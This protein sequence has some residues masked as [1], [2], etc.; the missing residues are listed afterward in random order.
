MAFQHQDIIPA[1]HGA[2]VAHMILPLQGPEHR[3]AYPEFTGNPLTEPAQKG[4]EPAVYPT[5]EWE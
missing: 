1:G 2:L 5:E 3:E 4:E